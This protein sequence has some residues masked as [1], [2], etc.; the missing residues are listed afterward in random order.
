M[1]NPG[2][3]STFGSRLGAGLAE[4][5]LDRWFPPPPTFLQRLADNL[6]VAVR[7]NAPLF[8]HLIERYVVEPPTNAAAPAPV[9]VAPGPAVKVLGEFTC[10]KCGGHTWGTMGFDENG[11]YERYCTNGLET[12]YGEFNPNTVKTPC[13][14]R[15][16]ATEDHLYFAKPS[17][18]DVRRA[19]ETQT[20][21]APSGQ[22]SRLDDIAD[23]DWPALETAVGDRK[24]AGEH[25]MGAAAR[26]LVAADAFIAQQRK[27]IDGLILDNEFKLGC[28]EAS[29]ELTADAAKAIG[30]VYAENV[31]T[32]RVALVMNDWKWS[33]RIGP[34]LFPVTR[35]MAEALMRPASPVD[36]TA[37]AQNAAGGVA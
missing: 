24:E 33:V 31:P 30:V 6:A 28:G 16:K 34:R 12:A 2:F 9:P 32:M 7:D 26:L 20:C 3:L 19:T 17:A 21:V 35:E 36:A 11:T 5:I 22:D 25:L 4:E 29:V 27:Q 18:E 10:P 37:M 14:F 15:W 1:R 23:R 8:A 13:M